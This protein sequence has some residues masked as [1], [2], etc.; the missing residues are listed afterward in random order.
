MTSIRT[1]ITSAVVGCTALV[2][3]VAALLVG[4]TA[5]AMIERGLD[6]RLRSRARW[7]QFV[8]RP[9]PGFPAADFREL[10]DG[11]EGRDAREGPDG[12][13]SREPRDGRDDRNGGDAREGQGSPELQQATPW[14]LV[15]SRDSESGEELQR[16]SLLPKE[17]SLA[18]FGVKPNDPIRTVRLPDGRPFRLLAVASE[19]RTFRW[20]RGRDGGRDAARESRE[21]ARGESGEGAAGEAEREGASDRRAAV[22]YLAA[23]ASAVEN[24]GERLA[25]ILAAV[26]AGATA[27]AWAASV[28]LSGA[29]LRPVASLSHTIRALSPTNLSA[30]VPME[31][32]PAELAP[33]V[34]RLNA[35]LEKVETAFQRERATIANM[36]HE[37][38]NPLSALRTTLE[39]G[40]FQGAS[41]QQRRTL[42]SSLA[43]TVRM[44]ALV[45][46]LLTLTRIEAG[47]ETLARE[48][49]DVVR[50]LRDA[51]NTL[52]SRAKERGVTAVWSVPESLPL[53]TSPTHVELVAAN[54]LDNAVSHGAAPGPVEVELESDGARARLRVTNECTEAGPGKGLFEPFFRSDPAR[55]NA[56]HFGLGL[57][58]CDRVVRLIG[59]TIEAHQDGRRFTVTVSFP[60]APVPTAPVAVG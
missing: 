59:G 54:L 37:L 27:L 30:R 58:L 49:V 26:W 31:E 24:E 35:L 12:R 16:S 29:V 18:D 52:E 28:T 41:P 8:W 39:F 44:Q 46:G 60:A 42:E 32:V 51:W 22:T 6:D 10:R 9:P 33:V 53:V 11:R 21:G 13:E 17:V 3:A 36:A 57:A 34:S 15:E 45:N 4:T 56:R 20:N 14:L 55:S 43:L 19:S 7:F 2:V 50:V 1:R 23:D 5:R 25:W 48:E 40:L 47:Q 38:R